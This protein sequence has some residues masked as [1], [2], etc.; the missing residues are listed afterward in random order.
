M[1]REPA[2]GFHPAYPWEREVRVF[3]PCSR[4]APVCAVLAGAVL[5]FCQNVIGGLVAVRRPFGA[6]AAGVDRRRPAPPKQA[7]EFPRAIFRPFP[8]SLK[9][10]A[11][12][13]GFLLSPFVCRPRMRGRIYGRPSACPEKRHPEKQSLQNRTGG[14]AEEEKDRTKF[15]GGGH[16]LD[17]PATAVAKRGA[18]RRTRP[19]PLSNVNPGHQ[20]K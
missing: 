16:L 3:P 4:P 20:P 5:T 14:R 7:R 2:F 13:T 12:P 6:F 11:V 15:G 1:S 18:P 19:S 17:M 10:T 9:Y 8:E